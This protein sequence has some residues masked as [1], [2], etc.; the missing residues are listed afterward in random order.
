M[1]KQ[2]CGFVG[3]QELCK[4]NKRVG[5]YY[6][7]ILPEYRGNGMAK[8][9]VA[10]ILQKKAAQVDYVRAFVMPHNDKSRQLANSLGIPV[11]HSVA[12]L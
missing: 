2:A 8:E 5:S 1:T 9:A 3:W 7:G 11:V 12:D 4:N 10:K 6:I